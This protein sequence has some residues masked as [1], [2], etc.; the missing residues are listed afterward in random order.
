MRKMNVCPTFK[1][2]Y[3]S[4][5]YTDKA[6]NHDQTIKH[7]Q[8]Y[9]LYSAITLRNHTFLKLKIV[10]FVFYFTY[11]VSCLGSDKK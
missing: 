7:K 8:Q 10:A 11:N 9:F 4:T 3:N 5:V 1:G 6:T 2:L